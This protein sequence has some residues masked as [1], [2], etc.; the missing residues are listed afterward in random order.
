VTSLA[1]CYLL[2]AVDDDVVVVLHFS[3]FIG[4]K[5]I[6][7]IIIIITTVAYVK[8]AVYYSVVFGYHHQIHLDGT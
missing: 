5:K 3:S 4:E 2:R 8:I 1:L 7:G 6:N